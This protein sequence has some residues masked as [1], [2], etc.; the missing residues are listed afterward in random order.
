MIKEKV[1]FIKIDVEGFEYNVLLGAKNILNRYSPIIF[2]EVF[3][4]NEDKVFELLKQFSYK[5]IE[6]L[7]ENNYIFM[8]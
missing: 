3:E 6:D 1:D 2:I 5:K 8:K 4:Q 7:G